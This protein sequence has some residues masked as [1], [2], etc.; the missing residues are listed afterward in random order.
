MRTMR[1]KKPADCSSL[2]RGTSIGRLR[3]SLSTGSFRIGN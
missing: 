1:V 2:D 3:C